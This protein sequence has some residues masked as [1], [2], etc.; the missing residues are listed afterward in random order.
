M[1]QANALFAFLFEPQMPTLVFST[2]THRNT[3]NF[4]SFAFFAVDD[5]QMINKGVLCEPA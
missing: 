2:K 1:M 3:K 4:A 5:S